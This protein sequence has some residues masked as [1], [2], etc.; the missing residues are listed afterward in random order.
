MSRIRIRATTITDWDNKEIVIPN[1]VFITD[2]LINWTLSD[3]ETR[4]VIMVGVAYGS[5][6]AKTRELLLQAADD[7]PRVLKE[8]APSVFF[9]SFGD[10][11]LNHELRVHVKEMGDRLITLNDLNTRIDTLFREHN[12]EIAFPQRD[13]HIRTTEPPSFHEEKTIR[14]Q[15]HSQTTTHSSDDD[16]GLDIGFSDDAEPI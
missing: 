5:D 1:K 16:P 7:D 13:I 12:I 14:P 6:L 10:S 3:P 9:L 8:P 4:V 11:T 15:K 2:Q